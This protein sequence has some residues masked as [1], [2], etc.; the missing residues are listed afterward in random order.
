MPIVPGAPS[1]APAPP[2][3]VAFFTDSFHEVN[4]VALTSR[5]FE[6]FAR[7][8][9]YP[10]LSVHCG[11]QSLLDTS[12]PVWTHQ[13]RRGPARIEL[14]RG[15]DLDPFLLRHAFA[16]ART[17]RRFRPTLVHITGPGDVGVLGAALALALRIPLAASWHT[18]LHEFAARRLDTLLL[19]FPAFL[20]HPAS[21]A[22]SAL[23]LFL[24]L[25]PYR[26][27]RLSLAPNPELMELVARHTRR[28]VFLMRRGVDTALFHPAP[29]DPAR[30]F[31]IG[32][33]GRLQAEKNVRSL[34]RLEQALL[35]A[36]SPPFRFLI[37]G[38]GAER[39]WLAS[40]LRHATLPGTLTGEP[41]ARAYSSMDV[42]VFPSRTDTF[43][44]VILEAM[45]SGVP[46]IV[47]EA[48]GPKFLVRS[49]ATGFV[50]ADEDAV[51][52]SVRLLMDDPGLLERMS[53]AARRFALS[54]SWDQTF[55]SVYDSYRALLSP[56]AAPLAAAP[57]VPA[58][59]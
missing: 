49:G 3:R 16:V 18:N 45:A 32:F 2:P 57:G 29:R 30:P 36:G 20:R 33:V 54:M 42:F 22:A 55:E 19:R 13:L 10:F 39:S 6:A 26:L 56:A 46:A 14:D 59:L 7:R 41:L 21:A 58:R 52:R 31:T 38:D 4:G 12:G 47:T 1:P 53:V 44:N 11:P 28:P 40:R 27:A 35:R 9:S 8:R 24:S 5:Q 43:G 15:L 51:A 48:G 34:A 25:L 17:L 23:T 50:T 37:V